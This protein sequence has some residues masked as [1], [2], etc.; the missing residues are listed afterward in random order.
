[1]RGG[2]IIP[3]RVGTS[4]GQ[5][6]GTGVF[7]DHPHA[8]GDK[9]ALRLTASTAAGSSPRVWGQAIKL[10]TLSDIAGIIPTRVGTR[11]FLS[12]SARVPRDHPHACGDKSSSLTSM[13]FMAG[14]SPR[15]WGQ[16]CVLVD[17]DFFQRI[18]PTRVGTS[19][20]I[21]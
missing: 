13:W 7:A 8:C 15:V 10:L 14:S 2:G 4:V 18:I 3:T 16:A 17:K 5:V 21:W 11:S 12:S 6:I 1:M 9:Q 19:M 20:E